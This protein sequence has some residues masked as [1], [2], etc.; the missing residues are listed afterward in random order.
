MLKNGELN[1]KQI[2]DEEGVNPSYVN[3]VEKKAIERKELD[4]SDVKTGKRGRKPKESSRE[5]F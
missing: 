5:N 2:A 4:D 3:H 1:Q